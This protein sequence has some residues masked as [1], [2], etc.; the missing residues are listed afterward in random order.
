[1]KLL[2][3]STGFT[4]PKVRDFFVKIL[5][6]PISEVKIIFIPTASRTEEELYY[7][8]ESKTELINI[9]I[10]SKNLFVY[11]LDKKLSYNK[12]RS[13][14]VIYTCGGNTF[15][16]TLKMREDG[17]D[18]IIKQLVKEGKLY[19]GVSAGS[20]LAGPNIDIASPYDPNDVKLKNLSGLGL[21]DIIVS[22]H[23]TDNDKEV[24]KRFKRKEKYKIVP[25]TDSQALFISD[26]ETKIIE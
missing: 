4:N 23:Y 11:N 15:Y 14:D 7:V 26:K 3:T 2:L 16:L 18:N 6:K 17:F 22:P 1:M 9:G 25:L 5:N 12:A 13:Y 21:T 20:I 10:K 8:K 19:F 24:V